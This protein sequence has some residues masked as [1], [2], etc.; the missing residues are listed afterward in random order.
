[1]RSDIAPD[2]IQRQRGPARYEHD[3]SSAKRRFK[4]KRMILQISYPA[5]HAGQRFG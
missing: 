3:Y 2:E 4:G 5:Q 1:M